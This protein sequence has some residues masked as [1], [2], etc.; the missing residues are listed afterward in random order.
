M[1]AELQLGPAEGAGT[2]PVLKLLGISKRFGGVQALSDVDAEFRAG[3]IHALLGENG[4]GKSTLLKIIDGAVQPDS[5]EMLID[6]APVSF[7]DPRDAMDR[8]IS[9]VYQELSI[10]PQAHLGRETSS[11]A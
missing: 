1:T 3:R 6:G 5:G 10:L 7:A 9:M 8:G 11:L 4:A 2:A